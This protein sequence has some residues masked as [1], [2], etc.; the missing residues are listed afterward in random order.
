M[1]LTHLFLFKKCII[2]CQDFSFGKVRD[3]SLSNPIR[4]LFEEYLQGNGS[5][6][7]R[8]ACHTGE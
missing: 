2:R 8:I 7:I 5:I 4:I 3:Y 1:S 6:V